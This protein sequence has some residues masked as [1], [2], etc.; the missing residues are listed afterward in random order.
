LSKAEIIS[1]LVSRGTAEAAVA[2]AWDRTQRRL[3]QQDRVYVERSGRQYRYGWI[4][5]TSLPSEPLKAFE[6]IVE[7]RLSPADREQLIELVRK[8]LGDGHLADAGAVASSTGRVDTDA[9]RA[10]AEMAIEV[11]ELAAKGTSAKAIIHRV[12][13]RMKGLRLE[14]VGVAGEELPFDRTQHQPIGPDIRDGVPVVVV[15]PGYIW[16]TSNG[17][18]LIERPVVQD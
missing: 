17:D 5:D 13:N 7:G 2:A 16:R 1:A 11:E 18:V 3:R 4:T 15:R 10:L 6:R 9:A 12:R 14:P 8:A